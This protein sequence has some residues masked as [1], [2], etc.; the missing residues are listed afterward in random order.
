MMEVGFLWTQWLV[1]IFPAAKII[2]F[3]IKTIYGKMRLADLQDI[4]NEYKDNPVVLEIIKARVIS[5]VYNNYLVQDK[6]SVS[7][8]NWG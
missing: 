3:T 1:I 4:V 2:T 6:K 8:V 5:Y 7:F